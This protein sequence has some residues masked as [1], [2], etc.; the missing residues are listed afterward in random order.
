MP[1]GIPEL[2]ELTSYQRRPDQAEMAQVS[3]PHCVLLVWE[4]PMGRR[5]NSNAAVDPKLCQFEAVR[6]LCSLLQVLW[7][8]E[9]K[10]GNFM[11][12]QVPKHVT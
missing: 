3:Y 1:V 9:F 12:T 7:K 10:E 6:Q 8:G 11:A 5:P 2:P 4:Q